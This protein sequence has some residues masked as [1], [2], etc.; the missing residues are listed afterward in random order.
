MFYSF[1]EV[2]LYH[3]QSVCKRQS[4]IQKIQNDKIMTFYDIHRFFLANIDFGNANATKLM[5]T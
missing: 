1:A 4:M 2:S 3:V 5:L